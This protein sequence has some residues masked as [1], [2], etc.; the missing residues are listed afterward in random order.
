MSEPAEDPQGE[1]LAGSCPPVHPV[2]PPRAL[3]LKRRMASRSRWATSL[4]D[5]VG[6][7]D[8]WV[9]APP[10]GCAAADAEAE[11]EE[12]DVDVVV[13]RRRVGVGRDVRRAIRQHDQLARLQTFGDLHPAATDRAGLHRHGGRGGRGGVATTFTVAVPVPVGVT[14]EAGTRTTLLADFTGDRAR[15]PWRRWRAGRSASLTDTLVV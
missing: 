3:N 5:A 11:A 14:A 7:A 9:L 8:A 15:T 2:P 13:V 4:A 1:I 6:R 10:V 12:L